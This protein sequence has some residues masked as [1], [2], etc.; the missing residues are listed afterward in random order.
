MKTVLI[1]G[2][3]S[4]IGRSVAIAYAQKGYQVIAGGRNAQ[5]LNNLSQ[6]HNNI[7]PLLCDV[8]DKNSIAL[9]SSSL[10]PIDILLLNAGDCEYIDDAL[11]FDGDLF[12]RIITTNVISV[13]Y[14]LEAWLP[15]IKPHGQLAIT[16]SSA[17]FLPLPRAEA[18]GASK[19]ALSYLAQT[20]SIDLA[21]HHIDV[22]LIHP[23][24]VSTQLTDKNTFAMPAIISAE[25]AAVYILKG[26]HQRKSEI[27]FPKRFI[28]FMKICALFPFSLWKALLIKSL[29]NKK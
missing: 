17:R 29:K 5:R 9:A 13:G 8:T 4:G 6:Q 25:H 19:A 1:T 27:N 12:A 23:G 16:S 28:F 20:L 24:F 7:T 18:Y 11:H 22:S 26:I 21:A 15:L 14:C 2:A 10:P 3:S